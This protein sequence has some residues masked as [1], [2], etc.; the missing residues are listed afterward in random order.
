MV[1]MSLMLLVLSQGQ[2]ELN[3][4]MVFSLSCSDGVQVRL[5][6]EPLERFPHYNYTVGPR[7]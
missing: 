6:G 3:Q 1:V 7:R 2:A 5:T 4:C